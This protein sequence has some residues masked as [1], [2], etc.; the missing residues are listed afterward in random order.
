M[1]FRVLISQ[2][3]YKW[4]VTLLVGLAMMCLVTLYVYL[5]NTA[6][7]ANRSMQL[8]MKNMGHNLLILPDSA[9]LRD[10]Y[11]CSDSQV[12]F[13]EEVTRQMSES[14]AL[15]SRYYVSVLQ[16][17]VEVDGSEVLLTGIEPVA[18][19]DETREKGNMIQ[20]LADGQARLGSE[21]ARVL[22]KQVGDSLEVRGTEFRVVEVL[23][24]KAT[25]DDCRVYVNL[26]QC[27]QLIGAAGQ[28]N[29][30]LA[31]L[32]LH[33][34]TLEE[35]LEGQ[36]AELAARFPGFRQVSR[37]DVAQGRSLARTTT[38]KSLY[39]L[40]ALVAVVT[41]IVIAVAGLQE[42]HDRRHETGI[43]L[44]MGVSQF[45]LVGLYLTKIL[46]IAALAAVAGFLLGSML[47]VQLT[48]SFLVVQTRAVAF[49]WSHLPVAMMLT[50]TVALVAQIL[51]IAKLLTL[52]PNAI[53][54][55]Q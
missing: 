38:Q 12:R 18:R 11:L 22:E 37:M 54:T 9:D 7:F 52:D 14:L 41:V 44:A 20:P 40:L 43:L 15:S 30:I 39:Y 4:V 26:L 29:Y 21:A 27:Q 47:A 25:I 32:C 28:I 33:L 35:S 50:A 45:Y 17:R 6:E 31:F 36:Q 51:P 10:L 42:V 16:E 3:R 53:L 48:S 24:P 1:F 5:N 13:A 23:P 46:A 49:V 19:K 8:V 2:A 34:G 55:E